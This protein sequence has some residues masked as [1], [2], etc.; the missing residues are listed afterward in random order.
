MRL[1]KPLRYTF[2]NHLET[3]HYSGEDAD[4]RHIKTLLNNFSL[5]DGYNWPGLNTW[6]YIVNYAKSEYLM[7][8]D[9]FRIAS[10]YHSEE[11]L[12]SGLDM[13]FFIYNND[14]MNVYNEHI[15]GFNSNFIK[16]QPK[17]IHNELIFTYTFRINGKN[18]KSVSLMQRGGYIT[19]KETGLPLYSIGMVVDVSPVKTDTIMR[20]NIERV[21]YEN[22]KRELLPLYNNHFYPEQEDKLLTKQEKQILNHIA[23]GLSSKQIASKLF[24]SEH[25]VVN[26]RKNMLSK[27][28]AKN[29]P[30]LVAFAIRKH[31]I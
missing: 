23:D 30:E 26:H 20:H 16:E 24:L 17:E 14:D 13:L 27:T 21:V 29:I 15:F 4:E 25:T 8:T 28:N 2:K 3:I 1:A 10:G 9:G 12:E 7:M 18:R 6:Y 5:I 22:G 19:S 11:A 31:I